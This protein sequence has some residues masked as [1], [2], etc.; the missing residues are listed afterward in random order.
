[1]W[2]PVTISPFEPS[3]PDRLP[4]VAPSP[5]DRVLS[6]AQ[7]YDA[8]GAGDQARVRIEWETRIEDRLASLDF[9]S[10]LR[11]AGLPW[12]EADAAGAV[13]LRQP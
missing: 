2:D 4:A 8:L 9:E 13:V 10:S 1:M 12:A 11:A 6:G 7:S 3:Q 5:G